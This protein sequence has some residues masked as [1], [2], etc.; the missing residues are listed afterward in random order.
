[1]VSGCQTCMCKR[2]I[3]SNQT[4]YHTNS[5]LFKKCYY[6]F[7]F[8]KFKY[9]RF[10]AKLVPVKDESNFDE[11]PTKVRP[12]FFKNGKRISNASSTLT[13]GFGEGKCPGR[14]LAFMEIKLLILTL[15]TCFD[16]SLVDDE[17]PQRDI[18]YIGF[19][20]LP[21]KHDVSITL[22]RRKNLLVEDHVTTSKQT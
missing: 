19:G 11:K 13:F 9:D 7:L 18:S 22:P 12:T 21:P 3:I 16:P 8:Q 15:L 14:Y 1:L 6:D 5:V 10:L 20:V 4:V 17:T 2:G